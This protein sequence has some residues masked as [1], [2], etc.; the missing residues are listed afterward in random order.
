MRDIYYLSGELVQWNFSFQQEGT[1]KLNRM[2]HWYILLINICFECIQTKTSDDGHTQQHPDKSTH[3]YSNEAKTPT[4]SGYNLLIQIHSAL[5]LCMTHTGDNHQIN[6]GLCSKTAFLW[7]RKQSYK[8]K[9]K[10]QKT[11][12]VNALSCIGLICDEAV[13]SMTING[14][15]SWKNVSWTP[16][17]KEYNPENINSIFLVRSYN[18]YNI[19]LSFYNRS[20]AISCYFG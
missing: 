19:K 17:Q 11:K 18:V 3:E 16:T 6:P 2:S 7:N 1:H 20:I 13:C 10:L 4:L 14:R 9:H 15:Y 12:T 8:T 5:Y